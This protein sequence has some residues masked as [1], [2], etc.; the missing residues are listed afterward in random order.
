MNDSDWRRRYEARIRSAQWKNMKRSLIKWRGNRC[1]RCGLET[2]LELHHKTYERLG[3][4]RLSDLE[5]ICST[6]HRLADQQRAAQGRQR[7]ATALYEAGLDTYATK[8]Y[9]EEWWM[10]HDSDWI[11]EEFDNWLERKSWEG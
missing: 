2:P 11:A 10:H 1:E 9:G 3:N 4:E 8:K 7:S 5:L 6:C